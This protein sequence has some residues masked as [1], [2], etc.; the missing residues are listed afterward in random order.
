MV[1]IGST[2]GTCTFDLTPTTTPVKIAFD[3]ASCPTAPLLGMCGGSSYT[4]RN[5]VTW[6]GT[7]YDWRPVNI[8]VVNANPGSCVRLTVVG[9]ASTYMFVERNGSHWLC[10]NIRRPPGTAII[11]VT[12]LDIPSVDVATQYV[13]RVAGFFETK[14]SKSGNMTMSYCN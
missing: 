6:T 10:T 7:S 5:L 9:R 8:R 2:G 4:D 3:G 12:M 14:L 13:Y 1:T 11:P